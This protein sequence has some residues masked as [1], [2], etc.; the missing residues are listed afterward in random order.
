MKRKILLSLAIALVAYVLLGRTNDQRIKADHEKVETHL[1]GIDG[2]DVG[3]QNKIAIIAKEMSDDHQHNKEQSV[4]NNELQLDDFIIEIED[5]AQTQS[6]SSTVNLLAEVNLSQVDLT[7]MA[8]S[9]KDLG[10]SPKITKSENSDT[11]AMKVL[12]STSSIPGL[13]YFHAQ[14]FNDNGKE[15]IQ[16]VSFEYR[17][18][19]KSFKEVVT[20]LVKTYGLNKRPEVLSEN[21]VLWKLDNDHILWAKKLGKEE[22]LNDPIY[23][24]DENDIGTTKVAIEQEIH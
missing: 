19:E 4:D 22:L 1:K 5:N 6:L 16:H 11:G 2:L 21:F 8:L 9:L 23:P 17:P 24:H 12:S 7:A 20:S 3:D 18:G 10:L 15:F 14:V 13:R